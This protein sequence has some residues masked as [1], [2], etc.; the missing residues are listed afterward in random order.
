[1][2]LRVAEFTGSTIVVLSGAA[3]FWALAYD[4]PYPLPSEPGPVVRLTDDTAV[5]AFENDKTARL[6]LAQFPLPVDSDSIPPP[7]RRN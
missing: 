4:P 3:F 5:R 2:R 6:A 7:P 1:M